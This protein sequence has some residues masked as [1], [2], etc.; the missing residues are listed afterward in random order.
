MALNQIFKFIMARDVTV[1]GTY[2]EFTQGSVFDVIHDTTLEYNDPASLRLFKGATEI[3]LGPTLT[4]GSG[5]NTDIYIA[6]GN[7]QYSGRIYSTYQWCKVLD[8]ILYYLN[9]TTNIFPYAKV[10]LL[11]NNAQCSAT[12]CDLTID[13]FD[14][15]D[16]TGSDQAD[17]SIEAFASSSG[18]VEYSLSPFQYG[19]GSTSG[20]FQNLLP[21]SYTVYVIDQFGCTSNINTSVG[22]VSNS[23]YGVKYR[24]G[25]NDIAG[26]PVQFD[27]E[28]IGYTGAITE[29]CAGNLPLV[30]EM[31]EQDQFDI[32]TTL[33][34]SSVTITLVELTK[35]FYDDLFTQNSRQY[36]GIWYKDLGAGFVEYW[37]GYLAPEV[38]STSY[39]YIPTLQVVFVDGLA[40]LE[41]NTLTKGSNNRL[42]ND[43]SL[44]N[45]ISKALK[46]TDLSL[47]IRVACNI[48]E[49]NHDS[50]DADDPF[51][52]TFIDAET[53]YED[54]ESKNLKDIVEQILKPF[55][56]RIVQWKGYW[57][58]INVNEN[59]SSFDYREFTKDGVY[60]S[61]GTYDPVK[62]ICPPDESGETVRFTGGNDNTSY[63]K[64]P[65]FKSIS[66]RNKLD[67][68]ESLIDN[69]DFSNRQIVDGSPN[70]KFN[71][72]TYILE[73]TNTSQGVLNLP[74]N[75]YA[76]SIS[77]NNWGAATGANAQD[78]YL[79]HANNKIQWTFGDKLIFS[80][81]V[82]VDNIQKSY[83]FMIIQ[84][85]VYIENHGYLKED[86]TWTS[87][88]YTLRFYPSVEN[89]FQTLKIE[90]LLPEVGTIADEN[91]EI[92]IFS[93]N[94]N[95]PDFGD[96]G[97]VSDGLALLRAEPT[98]NKIS[99]FKCSAHFIGLVAT[100]FYELIPGNDADDSVNKIRP[101][102]WNSSTNPQIYSLVGYVK[103]GT[104]DD[105]SSREIGEA[106]PNR[107][108]YVDNVIISVLPQGQKPRENENITI[109]IGKYLQDYTYEITAS[110][111]PD[112]FI[113][114]GKYL[115]KS[116][117]KLSDSTPTGVWTRD[118]ISEAQ[119][120]QKIVATTIISQY[121]TPSKKLSGQVTT[122]NRDGTHFDLSPIDCLKETQDND[123]IY[124][125][126]G[127][128]IDD[129]NLIQTVN[130]VEL[131]AANSAGN[132]GGSSFSGG[133]S[134]GY[135]SGYDTIFN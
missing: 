71:F 24:L 70:G 113:S 43:L 128:S 33:K 134:G 106:R 118:G 127:L 61:N 25:Y 35:F 91:I 79:Y 16:A 31:Y 107:F 73:G 99:G 64:L 37:R 77:V 124:Y 102:D 122:L 9:G 88:E 53:L 115:Y 41:S 23:S 68:R 45:I 111:L 8:L 119:T 80:F 55:A 18:T 103:T 26:N 63:E 44:I 93:Y 12:S 10:E 17:G 121:S 117:Y 62:D 66:I 48:Y 125:T 2:P 29:V 82:A 21:G 40:L 56:V 105:S 14:I 54:G 94:A 39:G 32:F 52:Q 6:S 7:V 120:I 98:V 108:Y 126:N 129:K 104:D 46:S 135:G 131:K 97:G 100:Y 96:V 38:F 83:P 15:T 60:S 110:D 57:W 36:K 123:L 19:N 67:Q 76:A 30:Y 13:N 84:A 86:G 78:A 47:P 90:T 3:F 5:S 87:S 28:E 89:D 50:T 20:I 133:F 51:E 75:D 81:D 22:F 95:S 11:A 49:E 27:I 42:Y 34:P 4:Y 65:A 1:S 92:K 59:G 109:Q 85:Q 69:Y 58:I 112:T 114:S 130:L 72:W 74:D 101:T 132:G 116:I